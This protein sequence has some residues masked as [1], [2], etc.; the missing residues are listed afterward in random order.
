MKMS[1]REKVEKLKSE[2]RNSNMKKFE[3]YHSE[4]SNKL[5]GTVYIKDKLDY[6]FHIY[7]IF[8][9]KAISVAGEYGILTEMFY[10]LR[11]KDYWI[12]R[13]FNKVSFSER[14][15]GSIF[16]HAKTDL[17]SFLSTD[18]NEGMYH[19]CFKYLGRMGMEKSAM[20]GRFLHRLITEYSYYELLYKSGVTNFRLLEIKNPEGRNPREIL[21]VNKS[22]WKLFSKFGIPIRYLQGTQS[23]ELTKMLNYLNYVK[24]LG[25][26]YGIDRI[27]EFYDNE[28]NYLRTGMAESWNN[29]GILST[30]KRYGL[31]ENRLIEYIYFEC[32]VSQGLRPR[33]AISEYKDYIRMVHEMEYSRVDNY[34]KALRTMHD[35][36]SMNYRISLDK[37]ELEEWNKRYE[38]NKKYIDTYQNWMIFPPE[39][40]EELRN[41]GNQQSHCVA[42]YVNNVREGKCI[43]LLLRDKNDLEKSLLTIEVRGDKIVQVR[44]KM[45]RLPSRNENGVISKLAERLNLGISYIGAREEEVANV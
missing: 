21:G 38:S 20:V 27:L 10:D 39:T 8:E 25:E 45:N 19:A 9:P 17:L 12:T 31:S 1:K 43:I 11:N 5:I 2:I 15:V 36:V 42:S 34:P 16:A 29:R 33:L 4:I 6:G 41:E 35:V 28:I 44:G 18:G 23:Q 26:N 22:G 24:K 14:N 30:A 13:D 32:E 40:P 3:I 37:E 7:H